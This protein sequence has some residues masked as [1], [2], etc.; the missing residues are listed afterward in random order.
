MEELVFSCYGVQVHLVDAADTGLCQRLQ[1][2]F[3]PECVAP[4]GVG[5]AGAAVVSYAVSAAAHGAKDWQLPQLARLLQDFRRRRAHGG[6]LRVDRGGG[7]RLL[8]AGAR[9][10]RERERRG[11]SRQRARG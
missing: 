10:R 2:T 7:L 5:A 4:T 8:R 1:E 3:P 6:G 9:G 11:R